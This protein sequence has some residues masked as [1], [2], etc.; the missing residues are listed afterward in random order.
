MFIMDGH[1]TQCIAE[2]HLSVLRLQVALVIGKKIID[3]FVY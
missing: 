2:A 3:G 1:D